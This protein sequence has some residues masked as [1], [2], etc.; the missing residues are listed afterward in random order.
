[1]RSGVKR[2]DLGV[3]EESDNLTRRR[4]LAVP[5]LPTPHSRLLTPHFYAAPLGGS[6]RRPGAAAWSSDRAPRTARPRCRCLSGAAADAVAAAVAGD[7]RHPEVAIGRRQPTVPRT[8]VE[9]AAVGE[10]GEPQRGD[11]HIRRPL[12]VLCVAEQLAAAAQGDSRR[13]VKPPLRSRP[14]A[15]DPRHQG[16]ALGRRER[17]HPRQQPSRGWTRQYRWGTGCSSDLAG[18]SG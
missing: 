14:R 10:Q 18:A 13:L 12:D 7:L 1:M 8:A 2:L 11:E 17:V 9:K 6:A 15:A 5:T 3:G 16:A 4:L